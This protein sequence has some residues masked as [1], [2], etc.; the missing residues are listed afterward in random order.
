MMSCTR[1]GTLCH[2]PQ[3]RQ[4][5]LVVCQNLIYGRQKLEKR[6][7][8]ICFEVSDSVRYI[9]TD[10]SLCDSWR[11]YSHLNLRNLSWD[12]ILEIA[13]IRNTH[14][15][16]KKNI[17]SWFFPPI[18]YFNQF[19]DCTLGFLK[20]PATQAIG[21]EQKTINFESDTLFQSI[22]GLYTWISKISCDTSYRATAEDYKLRVRL[23]SHFENRTSELGVRNNHAW[24]NLHK[25]W[26]NMRALLKLCVICISSLHVICVNIAIL[27]TILSKFTHFANLH[28]NECWINTLHVYKITYTHFA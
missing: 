27:H 22:W 9:D 14:P 19:E 1:S 3:T 15:A 8:I 24:T 13:L 20:F 17:N 23:T 12:Y 4:K 11:N 16:V 10:E 7:E 6:F 21:L 18:H 2:T 5:D 25:P 28:K 26:V